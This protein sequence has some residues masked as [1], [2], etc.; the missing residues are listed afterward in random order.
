[1]VDADD[2]A[3]ARPVGAA[4]PAGPPAPVRWWRTFRGWP[5]PLRFTTYGAV[6]LVLVL[7]AV[8]VFGAVVVRRSWPETDGEIEVPGLNAQAEVIRDEHGIPQIYADTMHDLMLAQGFV[9][10]QERFFEMDVRRHATSGRLAELFGEDALETDLVVRTLGWRRI[11]ERELT[12]LEPRTRDLLDA[13]AQGVNAYLSDRSASEISLEYALLGVTGLDYQPADWTAADS[14]AWLKAM[15][16]DLRGNLEEEIGRAVSASA[17]GE[18]RAA[19]LYPDYPYDAHP[20]IVTSGAVVD[21]VFEQDAATGDTRLPQRPAPGPVVEE[22]AQRPSRDLGSDE[23]AAV[24]RVLDAVPALLGKG[25]G[26]G[27]NAWVV[28]GSRTESGAP[29]LA[30]DPHLGVSLPGVWMQVGLH[31][32][33]VSSACPLDAAGFSFSGVPGVVIGHNADIAWGF[34]NLAPDTT[35]LF[36]ERVEG[37]RWQYD[38][39]M[40]P[41]RER[42][43]TIEVRDGED[44]ELVVRSTAHGPIL[45]DI[46]GLLGEQVADA[47][48]AVRDGDRWDHEVALAWTALEPRPTADALVALNLADDWESFRAAMAD[49]AAPGQ[50]VVYADVEGHIGYQATGLVPIRGSGNDGKVPAAG[51]RPENDWTGEYVPYDALP[52]VLDPESGMV[53][54]ANQSVIDASGGYPYFLTDDSDYGYRSSRI[55]DLLA[56]QESLTVEDM[57][58]MQY[59]D[60][61]PMAE[62]LVPYLLGVDPGDGYYDDGL[63]LLEGWDFR[64]QADSAAAAYFNVVW[65][66]LLHRAFDD[67]LPEVA[68]PDG[69]DRWFAAV[70]GL[71]GRP[72]DP[73]WD[74]VETDEVE[75]RD[76]ILVAAL[77]AA[78]DKLTA[79]Q[80]PNAEE[81]EWGRLHRLW[82]RSS[83]LGES[84]IGA[85]ERLFNRG[86]WELPAGGSLVNAT[87][88]DAREG[89]EVATAPSMRMV[90]PMDDLDAARWVS[91]TGVSGHAFHPHYTDQTDLWA[92]GDTLPWVFSREAVEDA[93]EDVLSL[94]PEE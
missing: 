72:G 4:R 41:L 64:Q 78:R 50:N 14:V 56:G 67:E 77:R 83:T 58:R 43:E 6:A 65:D 8:V 21:E 32:R 70:T 5:G 27:S 89:F 86:P 25:D 62:V 1:M 75:R 88:W 2:I 80:S 94:L 53:V 76:D 16:W 24:D 42:I 49:F 66:Q 81:W 34:T 63:A 47:G 52:S 73:W 36:V 9:H 91:L 44:V 3:P 39:R 87:G 31:C 57:S 35:D 74:D 92:R 28:D 38:G 7:V 46:D 18:D 26:I 85:V 37:D 11:A 40:L 71:L 93:G 82:L 19:A 90:V 59:D 20:P 60:R 54:T 10:A 48:L 22:V 17:V 69:G 84:G 33:E 55:G 15:A 29:I 13:Y 12:L 30:N 79:L 68:E 45:S 23:L 51:W 61:S